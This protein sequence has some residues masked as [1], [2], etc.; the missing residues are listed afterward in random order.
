M[1][2]R[3]GRPSVA[4]LTLLSIMLITA[5]WWALALWP[6][7]AIE[8]EWLVRTRAVCFGSMPGGLPD[9]GGWIVLVGEPIGM[10]GALLAVWGSALRDDIRRLRADGR[11]RT[12]IGVI[13]LAVIAGVGKTA[14]RIAYL[15]GLGQTPLYA[16]SN[17]PTIVDVDLSS[18]QLIDQR[19]RTTSITDFG[20]RS[21]ILTFAFGHCATVCPVVVHDIRAARA[22]AKRSDIPVVVITLDPWRDSPA[23]LPMI[24]S[25]WELEPTDRVLSGSVDAVERVLDV[26]GVQRRRD[27]RT[28]DIEHANVIMVTDTRGH[29]V[30]RIDGGWGRLNELIASLPTSTH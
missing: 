11:W 2:R 3:A 21:A 25:A 12:L 19:G 22:A 30:R 7:G 9:T 13:L 17:A 10:F 6:S 5:A 24:A 29:V 15:A 8:P 27:G 20:G 16:Q 4:S 14:Q 23:H 26:L 28:G 1:P 18:H